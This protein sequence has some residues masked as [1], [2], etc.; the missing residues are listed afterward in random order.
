MWIGWIGMIITTLTHIIIHITILIPISHSLFR[1]II[2]ITGI[3][4]T[5]LIMG[6]IIAGI[7]IIVTI[8]AGGGVNSRS[9]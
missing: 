7:L 4:L 2:H 1:S 5:I 3:I 6:T 8:I 9:E